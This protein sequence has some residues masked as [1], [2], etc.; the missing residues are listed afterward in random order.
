MDKKLADPVTNKIIISA[1]EQFVEDYQNALDSV[2]EDFANYI[3]AATNEPH[4]PPPPL[5]PQIAFPEMLP[6]SPILD[7]NSVD[8]DDDVAETRCNEL[9]CYHEKQSAEADQIREYDRRA[10][11][12]SKEADQNRPPWYSDDIEDTLVLFTYKLICAT[13]ACTDKL[14]DTGVVNLATHEASMRWL[15][16]AREANSSIQTF[17]GRMRKTN[18]REM[19]R[20]NL[21]RH[22]PKQNHHQEMLLQVGRHGARLPP[23]NDPTGKR[24][25]QKQEREEHNLTP[26]KKNRHYPKVPP[27]QYLPG[28]E[29]FLQEC[30]NKMTDKCGNEVME[31]VL[32]K[33]RK[34]VDKGCCSK[35][36]TM[37][38]DC[39]QEMLLRLEHLATKISDKS[40][41]KKRG[42]QMWKH[43]EKITGHH[44]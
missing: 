18:D 27:R 24:L 2:R 3:S 33:K 4:P 36:M 6:P 5:P 29:K 7:A 23:G 9:D 10:A 26:V 1:A 32:E 40:G 20:R 16:S 31:V 30:E 22:I 21:P 12:L 17:L 43:C 35:L 44:K 37:G 19:R 14:G 39:H 25:N 8:Y 41:V 11:A 42:H 15:Q 13:E 28:Y 34:N 38:Y